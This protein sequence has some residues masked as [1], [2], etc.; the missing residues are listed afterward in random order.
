MYSMCPIFCI[1]QASHAFLNDLYDLS[2][3]AAAVVQCDE[4]AKPDKGS[5]ICS[6]PLGNFSYLS[7]CQFTCD[8]GYIL[9]GSL[10]SSLV[11]GAK[12]RWNDTQ[13][14]C[15]GRTDSLYA[16]Y[17]HRKGERV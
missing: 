11:C 4:L 6:S 14:Q 7:L 10:S 3:S 16:C 17:K 15:E 8:K 5:M 2:L 12:A 1:A 9:N 13:P